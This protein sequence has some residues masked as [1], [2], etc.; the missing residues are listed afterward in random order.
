MGGG[1]FASELPQCRQISWELVSARLTGVAIDGHS[2]KM[3]SGTVTF[4]FTDI[5]GST[6]RWESEPDAMRSALAAHDEVLTTAITSHDGW[7]FKHT[8]DGV[9][10]AFTS[11]QDAVVAAVAAQLLLD[12]PVR[13]GLATGEAHAQGNDYFGPPL[14][15]AA[16][17]MAAGHGGQILLASSTARAGRRDRPGRPR[18]TEAPGPVGGSAD[19]PGECGGTAVEIP[20][21]QDGRHRAGQPSDA[22]NELHRARRSDRRARGSSSDST[23]W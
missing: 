11:A 15:R 12:L 4:L 3:P 17:V 20:P 16:R 21:A 6:R 18:L 9:I 19:L 10:A 1:L 5:E 2:A 7:L 22:R 14:N 13:M 23:G 8:G